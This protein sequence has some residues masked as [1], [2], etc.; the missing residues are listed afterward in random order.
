[1]RALDIHSPNNVIDADY[2]MRSGGSTI[3]N[4]GHVTLNPYPASIS[5]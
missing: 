4:Y 5:C 2:A 1:M 3:M